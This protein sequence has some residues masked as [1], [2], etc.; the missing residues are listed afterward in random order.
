MP[1]IKAGLPESIVMSDGFRKRLNQLLPYIFTVLLVFFSIQIILVSRPPRDF[2]E[3]FSAY[4]AGGKAFIENISPYSSQA[5]ELSWMKYVYPPIFA[6]LIIPFS[7]LPFST[8]GIIWV[9]LSIFLLFGSCIF[10]I[11]SVGYSIKWFSSEWAAFAVLGSIT[12]LYYP[13]FSSMALGQISTILLFLVATSFYAQAKKKPVIG[14]ILL[15]Q[16]GE[17]SATLW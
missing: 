10:I 14:G 11:R 8:A 2:V 4:W 6:L 17:N 16:V 15:V 1:E 9:T 7:L 5:L 12:A 3:D 13:S